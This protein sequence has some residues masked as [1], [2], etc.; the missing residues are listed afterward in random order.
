MSATGRQRHDPPGC[1]RAA[2][3]QEPTITKGRFP[4]RFR[5]SHNVR[6][7]LSSTDLVVMEETFLYDGTVVCDLRIVQRPIRFGTGDCEDPP[8]FRDDLVQ[9]TFYIEYGSTTRRGVF[10]AGGGA[11]PSLLAAMAHAEAAPGFGSTIVWT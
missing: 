8:E 6:M 7:Q 2:G 10:N 5:A 1:F 3:G 9:D 11:P 4:G